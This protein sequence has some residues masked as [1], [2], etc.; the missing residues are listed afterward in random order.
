VRSAQA[1][2]YGRR[3]EMSRLLDSLRAAIT[4]GARGLRHDR[5]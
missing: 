3:D 2:I 4:A 5:C 1:P